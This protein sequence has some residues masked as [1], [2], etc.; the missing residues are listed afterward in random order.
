MDYERITL[1]G[2]AGTGKS[3]V[4]KILANELEFEFIS[5][6]DFSREFAEKEYDD[7]K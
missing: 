4:G 1:S 2:F 6:G 3:T 5:V 7:D